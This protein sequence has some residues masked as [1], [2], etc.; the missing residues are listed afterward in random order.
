MAGRVLVSRMVAGRLFQVSGPATSKARSPILVLVLG[1]KTS[2]EFDNRSR[3]LLINK[4]EYFGIRGVAKL[5]FIDYLKNRS[6][7]VSLKGIT[8]PALEIK[9]G[10]PQGSILGP[11]LFLLYLN[12]LA[13]ISSKLKFILFADDT[14]AFVSHNSLDAL[15]EIINTELKEIAEWFNV[16][17]LSLNSDKINYILFRS[18]SESFV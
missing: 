8:S 10:E 14:N 4:L 11:L 18:L 12:D 3:D 1:M 13:M 2:D 7:Y 16:N 6:Q 9:C 15:F 17:K 5:W